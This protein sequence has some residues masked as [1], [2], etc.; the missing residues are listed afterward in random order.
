MSGRQTKYLLNFYMKDILNHLNYLPLGA[1][2]ILIMKHSD[3]ERSV[4]AVLRELPGHVQLVAAAKTRSANEVRAAIE[5]GVRIIGYNYVQEAERIRPEISADVKWHM[6]GHLQRN[7]AKKALELFDMVETL[8]S[9]KLART[10]DQLNL[11]EDRMT[12]ILIE[13]N[14]G[15]EEAKAG[16]FP[17]DVEALVREIAGMKRIRV[18]GLMTM[19]P[20][21]DD[22]EE[23]RSAIHALLEELKR[24]GISNVAVDL[25]GGKVPMSLGAFMAA[26]EARVDSLYVTVSY[27]Q[28]QPQP[29]TARIRCVSRPRSTSTAVRSG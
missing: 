26:E 24:N 17:E 13:V 19:G 1:G 25:T 16:V 2:D 27:E 5:A 9:A 23:A 8:D 10:I 29:E 22:P 3:I 21:S 18:M 20:F 28:G 12:Q 11:E 7:K 14:S 6:I 4:R 15:R